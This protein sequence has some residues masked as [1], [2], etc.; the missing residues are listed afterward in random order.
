[1]AKISA[2]SAEQYYARINDYIRAVFAINTLIPYAT[3]MGVLPNQSAFSPKNPPIKEAIALLE[4]P[5]LSFDGYFQSKVNAL[6]ADELPDHEEKPEILAIKNMQQIS[7][8]EKYVELITCARSKFHRAYTVQLLDSLSQKNTEEGMLVQSQGRN[9]PRRFH[10]GSHLL[11]ILVQIAVLKPV[12]TGDRYRTS[13]ISINDFMD[14]LQE[15]YGFIINGLASK[16]FA[17]ITELADNDAFRQNIQA[18]KDRLREIGFY[19]DLS[20][21]Y[22]SQ[23]IQ[24]RYILD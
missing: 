22:N 2:T 7:P 17:Q 9:R 5:P 12:G 1:M 23:T 16:S 19:T 24:P 3:T 20:D 8:Y 6:F 21:A 4:N 13:V 15:R 14:W 10:L 11:E 18:L